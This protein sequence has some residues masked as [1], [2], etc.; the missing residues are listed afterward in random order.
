MKHTEHRFPDD[1]DVP[2]NRLPLIVYAQAIDPRRGDPAVVFEDLF[3]SHGWGGSWR[4]GIFPFHHYHSNA[5]E[6]LGIA[7]GEADVRFGGERGE[8]LHVEAGDA[9]LI[10][11]GVG[12]RRLSSS[13]DLLV[14]GAYP[15]GQWADLMREGAEDKAGIRA[16]VAAV[17][18]PETDPVAGKTGPM[19]AS[20]SGAA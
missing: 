13:H 8:T 11:A 10:P 5:H 20:W 15:A 18:L 12:H 3:H 7:R 16:R 2:N 17:P 9:V 1:G 14:I 4:N 6:V 19:L